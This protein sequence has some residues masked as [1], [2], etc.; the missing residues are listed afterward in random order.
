V[1]VKTVP[2]INIIVI[3]FPIQIAVGLAVLGLSL[4]WFNQVFTILLQGMSG[5]LERLLLALHT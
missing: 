2:Q 1:V 5:Q 4:A 3:G